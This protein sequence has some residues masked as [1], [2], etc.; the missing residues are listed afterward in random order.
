MP[1]VLKKPGP[2]TLALMRVGSVDATP[3]PSLIDA[4]VRALAPLDEQA[5][6]AAS[7]G[8]HRHARDARRLD[9]GQPLHALDDL[10]VELAGP[11]RA[12]SA[13]G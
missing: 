4:I 3:P 5:E 7:A 8:H 6:D 13:G 2:M 10:A 1:S 12:C 9:T 11:G